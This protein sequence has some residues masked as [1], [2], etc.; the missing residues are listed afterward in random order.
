M[1]STLAASG[2]MNAFLR[3]HVSKVVVMIRV[4]SP[5]HLGEFQFSHLADSRPVHF[6]ATE[7]SAA[8]PGVFKLD[9]CELNSTPV[10][11]GGAT[12]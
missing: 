5:V 8:V 1:G 3:A 11:R 4:N 7:L 12:R 10:I 6:G 9:P 2:R